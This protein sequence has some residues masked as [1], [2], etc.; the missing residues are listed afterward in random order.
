MSYIIIFV[1]KVYQKIFSPMFAG[2]CRHYPSCS[3]YGIEAFERHGFFRGLYLT[4]RRI[5]RC[6]PFFEGGFDPVPDEKDLNKKYK[7]QKIKI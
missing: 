6:N 3:E 1:I 5:L 4:V 7:T 2:S